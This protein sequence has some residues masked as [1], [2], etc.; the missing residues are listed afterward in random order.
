MLRLSV[1]MQ[2]L[3]GAVGGIVAGGV[4]TGLATRAISS[5]ANVAADA[6][7]SNISTARSSDPGLPPDPKAIT[8]LHAADAAKLA[9]RLDLE[10]VDPT[11]SSDEARGLAATLGV[12]AQAAGFDLVGVEC[13]TTLCAAT[14]GWPSYD[15]AKRG[16][17]IVM[18][19][20]AACVRSIFLPE[21][22]DTTGPYQAT[23]YYDCAL[24]R[25]D[26]GF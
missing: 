19:A 25:G 26:A 16:Y 10:T 3:A 21:P 1:K 20:G 15:S 4:V 18:H 9:A 7:P 14:L 23:G 22:A 6:A 24:S 11:W 8:A 5:R 13:K 2:V 12:A 17:G